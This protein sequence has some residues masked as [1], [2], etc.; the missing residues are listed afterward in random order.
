[1]E[2]QFEEKLTRKLTILDRYVLFNYFEQFPDVDILFLM[3]NHRKIFDKMRQYICILK[4]SDVD[5]RYRCSDNLLVCGCLFIVFL[6]VFVY[7]HVTKSL[8]GL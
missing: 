7:M 5:V 8:L 3:I 2:K 1:M 6:S 4:R